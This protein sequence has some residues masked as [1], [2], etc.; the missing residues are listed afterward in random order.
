MLINSAAEKS[1]GGPGLACAA[2]PAFKKSPSF[3]QFVVAV[4]PVIGREIEYSH[5][6]QRIK[7]KKVVV[8]GGGPAGMQAAVT[9]AARGHQVVPPGKKSRKLGGA[10][11]S[12]LGPF[13]QIGDAEF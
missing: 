9:A 10:L 1:L 5:I 6:P 8:I 4:N 7:P 2:T 3:I 11:K 13:L 12:C